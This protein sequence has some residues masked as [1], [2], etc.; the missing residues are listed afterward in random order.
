MVLSSKVLFFEMCLLF[1]KTRKKTN[2]IPK[3]N[4][5]LVYCGYID[6][7]AV[8]TTVVAV[9]YC[10]K[11]RYHWKIHAMLPVLMTLFR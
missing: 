2:I 5:S 4:N 1:S 8:V 7:D 6:T 3:Y 10:F 11:I 9:L